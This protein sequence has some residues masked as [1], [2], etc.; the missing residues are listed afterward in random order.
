VHVALIISFNIQTNTHNIYTLNSVK[1]TLKHL[2]L[3]ATNFGLFLK[4]SSGG[5]CRRLYFAKLTK[6]GSVDI[7]LLQNCAVCGRM[8]FHSFFVCVCV[9]V[10]VSGV[11]Y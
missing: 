11:P 4:P 3:A 6:M 8:L 10:C 2:T 7:C 1:F 5:E 9:C